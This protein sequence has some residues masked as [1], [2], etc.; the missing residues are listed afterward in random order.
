MDQDELKYF[1]MLID[2]A[3]EEA[4]EGNL[5]IAEISL[6]GAFKVL[7]LAKGR[8]LYKMHPLPPML[9]PETAVAAQ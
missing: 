5:A 6:K 9:E 7:Q 4:A 1:K 3:K 2:E 8:E